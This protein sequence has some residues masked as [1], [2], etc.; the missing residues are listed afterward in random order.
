MTAY[1]HI[2]IYVGRHYGQRGAGLGN[3]LGSLGK[4]ALPLLKSTGKMLAQEG[5][6]AAV[7]V[8]SDISSGEKPL[9]SLKRRGANAFKNTA[10]NI[11]GS[12]GDR[13]EPRSVPKRKRKRVGK[14][15]RVF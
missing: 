1:D 8:V 3:F 11:I 15:G 7:N 12:F 5:L 13:A 6:K 9:K 2:P 10:H 14:R 4:I